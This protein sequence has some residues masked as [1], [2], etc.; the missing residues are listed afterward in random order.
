MCFG[1]GRVISGVRR[2]SAKEE[3]GENGDRDNKKPGGRATGRV[4]F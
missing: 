3:C 4:A 2:R 1:K